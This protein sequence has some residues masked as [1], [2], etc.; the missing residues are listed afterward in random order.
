MNTLW[1]ALWTYVLFRNKDWWPKAVLASVLVDF[2]FFVSSVIIFL[3][4]GI[5]HESWILAYEHPLVKPVGFLAHSYV[6]AFTA[7]GAAIILK[8]KGWLPYIYGWVF[9][10]IIDMLTHVSDAQP[11]LW[12]LSNWVFPAPFSYWEDAYYG[13]EF[14]LI[15]IALASLFAL[16]AAFKNRPTLKIHPKS[17]VILFGAISAY[18]LGI[19]GLWFKIGWSS[20]GMLSLYFI[21]GILFFLAARKAHKSW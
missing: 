13:D 8:K 18:L 6:T 9:H 14:G 16:Y 19:G 20:P 21:C 3:S 15:N 1:H 10:I 7:L 4:Q 5:S 17:Q 2:P 12:P 11:I